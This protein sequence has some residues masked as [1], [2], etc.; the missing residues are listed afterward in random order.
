MSVV[1]IKDV[2][3][4]FIE[5]RPNDRIGIV[6]FAGRP[7]L[8][9]PL[10]LDHEWLVA[11]LAQGAH[12]HPLLHLLVRGDECLELLRL[13]GRNGRDDLRL[14]EPHRIAAGLLALGQHRQPK[15]RAERLQRR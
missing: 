10:T 8:V 7:Y 12:D 2:T 13:F 5:G 15:L 3:K 11:R 14:D 1:E 9:S 6:A 4:R